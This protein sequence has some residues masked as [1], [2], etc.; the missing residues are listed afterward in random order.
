MFDRC[1]KEE[2]ALKET[3][4]NDLKE[5]FAKSFP[6]FFSDLHSTDRLSFH[7]DFLHINVM[8]EMEFTVENEKRNRVEYLEPPVKSENDK[9]GYRVIQLPNGFTALLISNEHSKTRASQDPD[10]KDEEINSNSD[11]N[12]NAFTRK[13]DSLIYVSTECENTIFYFQIKNKY[14]LSALDHLAAIL[15]KPLKKDNFKQWRAEAEAELRVASSAYRNRIEQLFSSFALPVHPP[16]KFPKDNFIK[17]YDS[18]DDNILYEEIVKFK[19]RHYSAHRIKFVVQAKL[20]LDT[21]ENNVT[22]CFFNVPNNGL[23]PDDFIKF[24]DGISFATPAFQNMYKISN[25]HNFNRLEIT[26]PMPSLV[27]FYK[28]KPHQ[29]ISWIIE[30]KGKGSLTSYLR[31]KWNC[32]ITCNNESSFMQTS[33]YTLLNLT[34]FFYEK[35]QYLEEFLNTIFSFINLLKK[36]G[37]Q[38]RIYDEIY[39]ITENDF[40]FSA[41][42]N[43]QFDVIH[44]SRSMHIYPSRNYITGNKL[45]FEYNATD[46]QKCL[47]YLTSETVNIMIFYHKDFDLK[48]NKVEKWSEAEYTNINISRECIERWKS[49]KP[50]Q[51]FHLPLP[52]IF[53]PSDFSL[54][55]IPAKV[56]KYPVKLL[57][58]GMMELWY[59]PYSKI[60]L[61]KCY[62]YFH[63]VPSMGLLSPRNAALMDVY[64]DIL[65]FLFDEEL[66]PAKAAGI[67]CEISSTEKGITI[68]IYGFNEKMPLLLKIIAEYMINPSLIFMKEL[69][70]IIRVRRLKMYY[71]VFTDPVKLVSQVKL[72]ILKLIQYSHVDKHTALYQI[73]FKEFKD[74]VKS[75]TRTLYIQC[76]IQGNMTENAAIRNVRQF[77]ERIKC[78][79]LT[80]NTLLQMRVTQIPLGTSYCKLKIINKS[81]SKSVVTNYYQ[82]DVMSIKLSVLIELVVYIIKDSLYAELADVEFE[83]MLCDIENV[84][85]ILGYFITICTQADK[86]TIEYMDQ[87]IEKY[88]TSFKKILNEMAEEKFDNYKESIKKNW[89]IYCEV[90]RNWNE[91]IKFEYMFN[92]FE[93]KKLALE[94]IKIDEIRKWFEEHTLNGKNFR[95]LSIQ[96][97]GTVPKKE[98]VNEASSE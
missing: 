45:Y 48:L 71:D 93:K 38:K 15:I 64:C 34:V 22:K 40:R 74:F 53:L 81:D 94:D 8:S 78:Y 18:I 2:L 84:N 5:C 25:I 87:S 85:G 75:F 26:W 56:P 20:P 41:E 73:K 65:S 23:P 37:P 47:N 97:V 69:F 7:S 9:K 80:N 19:T 95:K 13:Y 50:L 28:S 55:P 39:K 30:H 63:F 70:E 76:L 31:K 66:Y 21:L 49:I 6:S 88:L 61:P 68:K 79:P 43:T 17:L 58:S 62:M 3:Q 52:N 11:N 24:K 32:E 72:T 44:L 4:I 14:L 27:D 33:M 36:E 91:I 82:A 89:D 96:M 57:S 16:S 42:D 46:I 10:E 59:H 77:L 29:Y 60:C 51:D 92:R 54:I 35:L 86:Y 83:Y 98:E 67:D 1:E 90:A 12:F